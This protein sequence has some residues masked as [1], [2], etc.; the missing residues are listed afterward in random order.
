MTLGAIL[1]PALLLVI[2]VYWGAQGT[3]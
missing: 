2:L 1:V 3:V